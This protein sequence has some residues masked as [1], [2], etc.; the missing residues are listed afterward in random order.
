M[1][2]L[3]QISVFDII[4]ALCLLCQSVCLSIRLSL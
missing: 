4:G 3:L 1:Y 2:N